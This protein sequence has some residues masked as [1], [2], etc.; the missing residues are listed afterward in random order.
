MRGLALASLLLAGCLSVPAP[1]QLE[2]R[3]DVDCNIARGE[4]CAE[5]L[6]YGDPPARELAAVVSPP[7]GRD[8]L[9]S[10][11]IT[12]LSLDSAGWING[13][14]LERPIALKGLL[15][16]A[17]PAMRTCDGELG[18]SITATRESTFSG[19]PGFKTTVNTTSNVDG[20]TFELALPRTRTAADRYVVT[21]VPAGRGEMSTTSAAALVPP[22]RVELG[23]EG[24]LPSVFM[25]GGADLP[26][27]QGELLSSTGSGLA[28][29]RVVALGRWED[30]QTPVEVST[31]ASTGIDGRFSLTLARGLIGTVEIVARP[32]MD[33][34]P[35]LRRVDVPV[36]GAT[37]Q[38]LVEPVG[39]RDLDAKPM[40][41]EIKA[42]DGAGEIAPVR[43][44][45]VRLSATVTPGMASE[46]V[47]SVVLEKSTD[48]SGVVAFEDLGGPMLRDNYRLD[49]IPPAGSSVGVV[50]DL[51]VTYSTGRQVLLLP[52]RVALRGTVLDATGSP[53][54]G[55]PV[56]ARP[57]LRFL[58]SLPPAVQSLLSTVPL[59]TTSTSQEGEF[60]V[61]VDGSL[62]GII[63]LYDLIVEPPTEA[64]MRIR[65][66]SH[67][68]A[69]IAATSDPAPPSI[70]I[71]LPDAAFVRGQVTDAATGGIVDDAEL[72]VFRVNAT[73]ALCA[74]VPYAPL[75][76]PIP[77]AVEGRGASDDDGIVRI[78]LPR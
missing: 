52:S 27:V 17:C 33:F 58:W 37:E 7:S 61:W 76:C 44:A 60:V 48:D 39:L 21:I 73:T 78:T 31:V 23:L 47:A 42:K 57:S 46:T 69:E 55:V 28:N 8:D 25:L 5:G 2:C 65:A 64:K 32:W 75:S 51:A 24:S 1:E 15:D 11:E 40:S 26:I 74:N 14:V 68:V 43:G 56:T 35:T 4:V 66:G 22:A 16:L 59:S 72:R 38:T 18:A 62:S 36:T 10:R 50:R 6:C 29:Y 71:Q 12:S 34:A 67:V 53:L 45:T 30:G 70:S 49:V 9:V 41:L 3:S 63:G 19:G 54:S 20:V 13:L 77:A